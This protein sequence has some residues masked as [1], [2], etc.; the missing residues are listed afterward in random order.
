M[1]LPL[2]M[3]AKR[4]GVSHASISRHM[5]DCLARPDRHGWGSRQRRPKAGDD[6]GVIVQQLDAETAALEAASSE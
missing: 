6:W 1:A 5:R 2:P 4:Y 3:L